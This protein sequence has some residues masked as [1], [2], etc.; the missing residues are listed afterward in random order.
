MPL[1]LAVCRD[2]DWSQE[3]LR[4][5][6]RDT[7]VFVRDVTFIKLVDVKPPRN[8][9]RLVVDAALDPQVDRLPI[10]TLNH[11]CL[12][13]DALTAE[14]VSSFDFRRPDGTGRILLDLEAK[15]QEDHA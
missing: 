8:H 4:D 7:V 1:A 6:A 2:L 5:V 3:E 12:A 14:G 13:E 9:L 11:D 10:Y 15:P